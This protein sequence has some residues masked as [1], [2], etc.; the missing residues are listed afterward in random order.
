MTFNWIKYCKNQHDVVCNQKYDDIHLYS[1]HLALVDVQYEKWKHLL[2]PSE[3]DMVEKAIWGHDLIE[4]ARVTY[5]DV[6]KRVGTAVANIIF[7][8]TDSQGRT[9]AERKD[10]AFWKRLTAEELSVFV[11]LC[12]VMANATYSYMT[13]SSMFKKY[14]SE[15]PNF[16]MKAFVPR[17]K[18]MFDKLEKI[19]SL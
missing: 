16:K 9:R 8:V 11:K 17:F 18:P 19:L 5:K 12:D 6:E 4:D 10:D 3:H 14:G 15:F 2:D 1:F 13:G 7:G